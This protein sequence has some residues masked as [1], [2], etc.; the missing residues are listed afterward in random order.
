MS[1]PRQPQL[2]SAVAS[3]CRLLLRGADRGLDVAGDLR[4]RIEDDERRSRAR[5]AGGGVGVGAQGLGVGV[6]VGRVAGDVVDGLDGRVRAAQPRMAVERDLR[7]AVVGL[8]LV[9]GRRVGAEAAC[10]GARVGGPV[11]GRVRADGE[12]AGGG[13]RAVDGDGRVVVQDG[14]GPRVDA[15][16]EAA[17]VR[18]GRAVAVGLGA[19]GDG[20]VPRRGEDRVL[21]DRHVAL[22]ARVGVGVGVADGDEAAAAVGGQAGRVADRVRGDG[23]RGRGDPRAAAHVQVDHRQ[24]RGVRVRGL[25][26]D[27]A[28]AAAR[29]RGGHDAVARR[30][31]GEV[32][33]AAGRKLLGAAARRQVEHDRL[34]ARARR[35]EVE[36]LRREPVRAA[37][38]AARVQRD[39]G[40][41]E[42]GRDLEGRRVAA[43]DEVGLAVDEVG[44]LAVLRALERVRGGRTRGGLVGREGERGAVD[45][46]RRLAG[47]RVRRRAAVVRGPADGVATRVRELDALGVEAD[48]PVVAEVQQTADDRATADGV[49]D[50]VARLEAVV[51]TLA[52]EHE[53][54]VVAGADAVAR[55]AVGVGVGRD[56]RVGEAAVELG[57]RVQRV[58]GDRRADG[59]VVGAVDVVAADLGAGGR[60][61]GEG[62]GDGQQLQAGV[63]DLEDL[64]LRAADQAPDRRRARR[65]VVGDDVPG[66]EPVGAREGDRVGRGVDAG[67]RREELGAEHDRVVVLDD[68]GVAVA[69]GEAVVAR[70]A[71]GVED[72]RVAGDQAVGRARQQANV[73]VSFAVLT[74]VAAS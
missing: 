11:D 45:V 50:L 70:A 7:E 13:Q 52:G 44:Q 38:Q 66:V 43:D 61:V 74:A 48:D 28:T 54:V 69:V 35:G 46:Q 17:R 71:V 30:G 47:V 8:G 1:P 67:R 60:D 55:D 53:L 19:R 64:V 33:G 24:R 37:G 15:R 31:A 4:E 16:A 3:K 26:V 23:D 12:V 20:D 41:A 59:E 57:G 34:G 51:L 49:H 27:E 40:A 36:A 5:G 58:V 14:A 56:D 18:G 39:R 72:D 21:A 9:A 42:R 32:R 73:I 22:R 63:V 25:H 68:D 62:R 2:A 29:C 6:R 10:V 65:H